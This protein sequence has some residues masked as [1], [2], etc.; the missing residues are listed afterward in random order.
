M[1]VDFH[2]ILV[3]VAGTSADDEALRLACFLAKKN[4][5]KVWVV[6]IIILKRSLPVDAEVEPEIKRGEEILDHME[7][8]AQEVDYQIETDLL[9]SREAGPTIIDEAVGHT[10]DLILMG[11]KYKRRLGQFSLGSVIPYV[12][13]NTPCRVLLYQQ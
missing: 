12:L 11:I 9:Q 7:A 1:S 10:V 6:Y 3:P 13:K 5:A 8:V 4:K 2:R